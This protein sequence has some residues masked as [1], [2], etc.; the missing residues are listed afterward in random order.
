MTLCEVA[1]TQAAFAGLEWRPVNALPNNSDANAFDAEPSDTE[2][3]AMRLFQGYLWYPKS[4]QLELADY[5]PPKLSE[6]IHLLWD[7]IRPP[8]TFFDDGTPSSSQHFCQLTVLYVGIMQSNAT[9]EIL[10]HE[11]QQKLHDKLEQTPAGVGWQLLSDL[12]PA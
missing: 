7:E 8:F 1:L 2:N 9:W 6:T 4:L 10:L 11:C 5:L 3:C 12:R